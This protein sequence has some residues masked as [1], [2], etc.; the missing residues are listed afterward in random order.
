VKRWLRE[1]ADD[2]MAKRADRGGAAV[3]GQLYR[4]FIHAVSVEVKLKKVLELEERIEEL[5]R[6]A[7]ARTG[8]RRE[9]QA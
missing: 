7:A 6:R 2:V 3:A 9:W 1:R 8:G 5:E 4:T